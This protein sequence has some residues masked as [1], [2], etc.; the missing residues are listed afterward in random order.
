MQTASFRSNGTLKRGRESL[1]IPSGRPCRREEAPPC[2]HS[3]FAEGRVPVGESYEKR[4]SPHPDR[5]KA[6]SDAEKEPSTFATLRRVFLALQRGV[7]EQHAGQRRIQR[8][9]C[10]HV[11]NW[12]FFRGLICLFSVIPFLVMD[13]LIAGLPSSGRPFQE[14]DPTGFSCPQGPMHGLTMGFQQLLIKHSRPPACA[15]ASSQP[16]GSYGVISTWIV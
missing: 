4:E 16:S 15:H 3:P 5:L 10:P 11:G 12:L 13:A 14:G 8:P 9:G 6:R 2:R 7:F 1:N